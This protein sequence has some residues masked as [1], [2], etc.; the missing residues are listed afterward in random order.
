MSGPL[1]LMGDTAAACEGGVCDLPDP[2]AKAAL[3]PSADRP[4]A[5]GDVASAPAQGAAADAGGET[6][7]G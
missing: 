4:G 7:A 6:P 5:Q 2:A 1:I 3:S